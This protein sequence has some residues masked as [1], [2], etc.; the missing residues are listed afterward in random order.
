MSLAFI[1]EEMTDLLLNHHFGTRPYRNP[2]AAIFMPSQLS[3]LL[4][5]SPDEKL[6]IIEALCVRLK[7]SAVWIRLYRQRDR[8]VLT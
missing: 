3:A 7:R 4:E 6:D 2:A 5:L 1:I 8:L